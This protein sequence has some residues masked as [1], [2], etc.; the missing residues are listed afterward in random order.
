MPAR[1][2]ITEV[3]ETR[4]RVV[5]FEDDETGVRLLARWARLLESGHPPTR[6]AIVQPSSFASHLADPRSP[7]G[8]AVRTG[9]K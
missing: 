8:A 6:A 7:L 1:I 4:T 9:A 5:E 2:R 3:L